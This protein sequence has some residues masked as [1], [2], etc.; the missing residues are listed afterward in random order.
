MV[1]RFEVLIK[2]IIEEHN[3]LKKENRK[4]LL[5]NENLKIQL[6]QNTKVDGKHVGDEMGE[7]MISFQI[8]S[9]QTNNECKWRHKSQDTNASQGSSSPEDRSISI[10]RDHESDLQRTL[11]RMSPLKHSGS[12]EEPKAEFEVTSS[13][14]VDSRLYNSQLPTQYSDDS[15]PTKTYRPRQLQNWHQL[16]SYE[17]EKQTKTARRDSLDDHI[18]AKEEVSH[19][20]QGFAAIKTANTLENADMVEDSEEETSSILFSKSQHKPIKRHCRD[21]SPLRDMTNTNIPPLPSSYTKLQRRQQMVKFYKDLLQHRTD[22]KIDLSRNPINESPWVLA[23][24][25]PNP[26]YQK[27]KVATKIGYSKSH[28]LAIQNFYNTANRGL[29][30][31]GDVKPVLATPNLGLSESQMFDRIPSPPGFM[32]SD[33]PTSQEQ[34]R[35]N[36]LV[37]ARQSDRLHRRLILCLSAEGEFMFVHDI[38]NSYVRAK[39]YVLPILEV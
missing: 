12:L 39:R 5:E 30:E 16:T 6:Q 3:Q 13:P 9:S 26:H 23:D 25:K 18:K 28:R 35:R 1:D 36:D 21:R 4:L 34:R 20:I 15:S 31:P 2:G 10:D 8:Q 24:F 38:L 19:H 7:N 37:A 17:I 32:M 27:P 33:F 11:V 29:S 22:F 14:L